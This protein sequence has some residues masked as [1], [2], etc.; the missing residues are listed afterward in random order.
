M[1]NLIG[2]V[3]EVALKVSNSAVGVSSTSEDLLKATKDISLT[4]EHLERNSGAGKRYESCLMQMTGLSDKV[5]KVYNN[6]YEIERIANDTKM[7]SGEVL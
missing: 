3:Q 2:D 6:S 5:N 7:I 1:R 4:I